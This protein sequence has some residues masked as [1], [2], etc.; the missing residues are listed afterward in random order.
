MSNNLKLQLYQAG[1]NV[2]DKKL[3]LIDKALP[4]PPFRWCILGPTQAG[5]STLIRNIL[6][7]VKF[8]YEKYFD[9]IYIFIGS[10]D[11]II[12]TQ[13]LIKRFKLTKKMKVEQ[14]FDPDATSE[15]FD[16]IEKDSIKPNPPK[17]LMI[18][19]DQICNSLCSS[20]KLGIIDQIFVRGRHAN[21][22]CIIS[23]QK[24]MSLN[25]NIRALNLSQ[26]TI[27]SGT[28]ST[29]LD[30]VVEEHVGVY[31]EKSMLQTIKDRI[32]QRY[33]FVT[34]DNSKNG[35]ERLLDMLFVPIKA[36]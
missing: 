29:D 30:K 13:E 21:I 3:K 27:F 7:N 11:D 8:G 15:L 32:E 28:S 19:D 25:N 17:V 1:S 23:S 26:L 36:D 4:K 12:E 24:Y 34:I 20:G 10:L 6:F 22:S 16:S 5:K 9:E 33:N 18:F 2:V 35:K 31:D 14:K